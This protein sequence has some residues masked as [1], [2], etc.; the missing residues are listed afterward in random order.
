[1]RKHARFEIESPVTV[2]VR[3]LS[4]GAGLELGRLCDIGPRGA[5]FCLDRRLRLDAEVILLV[6]FTDPC[7]R[8]TTIRFVGTVMR[9]GVNA[10]YET[11]VR[12]RGSAQ[13]LRGGLQDILRRDQRRRRKSLASRFLHSERRVSGDGLCDTTRGNIQEPGTPRER[14]A[15]QQ[16]SNDG[17]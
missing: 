13:F 2:G 10:P 1:M 8:D 3:D 11:A 16:H 7:G 5:R 15:S 14:Q 4:N 9:V 6:H 17:G 12:F